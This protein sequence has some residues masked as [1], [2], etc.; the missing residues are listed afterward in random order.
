[1]KKQFFLILLSSSFALSCSEKDKH[2]PEINHLNKQDALEIAL[3]EKE[4]EVLMIEREKR[5]ALKTATEAASTHD[6]PP[7]H[8][9]GLQKRKGNKSKK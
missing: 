3:W 1:M 2:K 8:S 4:V 5:A 9:L 7:V 6:Q